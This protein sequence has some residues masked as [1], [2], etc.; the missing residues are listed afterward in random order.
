MLY[1]VE[2]DKYT[3]WAESPLKSSKIGHLNFK[4]NLAKYKYLVDLEIFLGLFWP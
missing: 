2:G 1:H 3:F 4:V